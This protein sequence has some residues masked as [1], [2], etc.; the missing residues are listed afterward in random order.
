MVQEPVLSHPVP[1]NVSRAPEV[2]ERDQQQLTDVDGTVPVGTNAHVGTG[3]SGNVHVV[4][5]STETVLRVQEDG[6]ATLVVNGQRLGL[7]HGHKCSESESG[8]ERHVC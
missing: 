2:D 3:T 7:S 8:D 1:T 4:V 5:D 6:L